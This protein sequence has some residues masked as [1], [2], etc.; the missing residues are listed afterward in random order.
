MLESLEKHNKAINDI[1]TKIEKLNINYENETKRRYGEINTR[2]NKLEEDIYK[3]KINRIDSEPNAI[4][5]VES[6]SNT[7]VINNNNN[8]N[9][10]D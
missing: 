9:F 10:F 7:L 2:I 6:G 5:S 3:L 4:I 1:N 8:I